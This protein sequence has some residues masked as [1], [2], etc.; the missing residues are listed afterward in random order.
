MWSPVAKALVQKYPADK[1]QMELSAK[2]PVFCFVFSPLQVETFLM[3]RRWMCQ[4]KW[5]SSSSRPHHMKTCASA[6][7]AGQ[8]SSFPFVFWLFYIFYCSSDVDQRWKN[9]NHVCKSRCS[10]RTLFWDKWRCA[11]GNHYLFSLQV[12]LLVKNRH[13]WHLLLMAYHKDALDSKWVFTEKKK[14]VLKAQCR[15]FF[16]LYTVFFLFCFV[17][18]VFV[19]CKIIF[20]CHILHL[21]Q[22]PKSSVFTL[23]S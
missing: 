9:D 20:H 12:S 5:S 17:F 19:D 10:S 8:Y 13:P 15:A 3:M 1:K 22:H 7:L 14:N 4:H 21:R 23:G 16:S 11:P 18:F 6:T 2:D